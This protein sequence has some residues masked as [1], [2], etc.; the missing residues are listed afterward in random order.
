LH[1]LTAAGD[2]DEVPEKEGKEGRFT[3]GPEGEKEFQAWLSKQPK[4]V[5]DDWKKNKEKYK[6]KFKSAA[7]RLFQ[8]AAP[9]R[10]AGCEKLPNE[11]MQQLCEDKRKDKGDKEAARVTPI[12]KAKK[13]DRVEV[14]Y[15]GEKVT[16]KVVSVKK[17]GTVTVDLSGQHS[18]EDVGYVDVRL[19]AG[20]EASLRA[21]TIRL[22]H[23]NPALDFK[24]NHFAKKSA[25]LR[26]AAIRLAYSLPKGS[27][28]R[29]KLL[30]TILEA[31]S[32]YRKGD[33][34]S[35]KGRSYKLLYSGATKFGE[36]AK[37]Q[38]MDG[39]KE[40]WVLLNLISP[41]NSGGGGGGGGGGRSRWVTFRYWNGR[42]ERMTEED[43]EMA[44]D[45]GQG[46]V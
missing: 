6:D 29:S 31:K 30:A 25:L 38:F 37:L 3:E 45:M 14:T 15:K 16:G 40:F 18:D 13:G 26:R 34:V 44:E 42:T 4:A 28:E 9:K 22:A 5:Q 41:A 21:A 10:F 36:K 7:S 19:K 35:Y 2:A 1:A 32:S 39:T 27:E 17:D 33:I 24:D 20:K 23:S 8:A 12:E 46:T 43:A 11:K